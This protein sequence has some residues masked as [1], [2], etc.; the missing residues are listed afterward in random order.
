M[1]SEGLHKSRD[2]KHKLLI[3]R[4]HPG[5]YSRY[6]EYGVFADVCL[7]SLEAAKFWLKIW[8]H[9]LLKPAESDCTALLCWFCC[10]CCFIKFC[11]IIEAFNNRLCWRL[12]LYMGHKMRPVSCW[13]SS[14]ITLSI[15]L[16]FLTRSSSFFNPHPKGN[17]ICLTQCLHYKKF[18]L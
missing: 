3:S 6:S 12:G 5:I 16:T 18:C 2:V 10:H 17:I 15:W 1:Q 9:A 4:S 14:S 11:C 13:S 7:E 8:S